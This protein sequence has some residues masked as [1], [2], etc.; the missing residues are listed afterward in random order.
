[1]VPFVLTL[2]KSAL[3]EVLWTCNNVCRDLFGLPKPV[4]GLS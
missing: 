4:G 2:P 3:A 1:M